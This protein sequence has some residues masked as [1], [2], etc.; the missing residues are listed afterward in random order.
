MSLHHQP[1]QQVGR[2]SVTRSDSPSCLWSYRNSPQVPDL[3]NVW[4]YTIG[5]C[6]L[7]WG[8][9]VIVGRWT[10]CLSG[11]GRGVEEHWKMN[12]HTQN[13]NFFKNVGQLQGSLRNQDPLIAV[14]H[15][16]I[17]I[18]TL[19]NGRAKP[20]YQILPPPPPIRHINISWT[21]THPL[22]AFSGINHV[23]FNRV[24]G[25]RPAN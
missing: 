12:P 20:W 13:K 22:L 6:K 17:R 5:V 8:R 11:G 1:W 23:Q 24:L 10:I 7:S 21:R 9:F 2:W 4:H 19:V 18:M 3:K 25:D 16:K 14:E 15:Q